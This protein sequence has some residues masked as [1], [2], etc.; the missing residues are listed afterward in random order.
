MSH[1]NDVSPLLS[2]TTRLFEVNFSRSRPLLVPIQPQLR[3]FCRFQCPLYRKKTT[4]QPNLDICLSFFYKSD[5]LMA[6]GRNRLGGSEYK[7]S[8]WRSKEN[9]RRS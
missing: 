2:T 7:K 4:K 3:I 1:G 8:Q 5:V 9:K 6:D